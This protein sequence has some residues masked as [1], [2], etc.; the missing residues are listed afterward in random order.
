[1]KP[2]RLTVLTLIFIF[3]FISAASSQDSHKLLMNQHFPYP[4]RALDSIRAV[5]MPLLQLPESYR[6]RS[7]PPWVDNT[8]NQ[9]WPGV[10]DQ[11]L[12]SSCQQY[13]GVAYVFGYEI[14]RLRN[15]PG[16]YWEN[17]YPTHYTWNFM[18][19]GEE[20]AGVNFFESFEVIRQQGHMTSN[21]YGIDTATKALGW[22]SGYDKYYRGMFNHLKQ[23]SAIMT[24]STNGVNTL[25]N[26]LFDHLNG[27]ATG[28]IVCFTTD[29]SAIFGIPVIPAGFPEAGK[30]VVLAW[31]NSPNHGMTV[32][33]YNDSVKYDVNG[34]GKCTND[35]DITGDGIVDARDWEIGGFKIANSY[36]GGSW[37]D[38]G[39]TYALYRSFALNYEQG[40]VWNNR[41]YVVEADTA[42]RPL[43][44]LKVKLNYNYRDR[45]RILA[46]VGS[47]TM[48]QMPE[49]VIDF[50]IFN[51][52]G[53]EHVMQGWDAKPE[54]TSIEFGLDVTQLLNLVPS[55]Q[56]ARYFL[57]VEERDSVHTGTGS[58]QKASFIS[59]QNG[60]HEFPVNNENVSIE[61]N[62]VTFVSAVASIEK[63]D[64]QI[65]TNTLPQVI[66]SQP[67]QTQLMA[68]GG[69]PPYDWSFVEN[70]TKQPA[71]ALL[72]LITGNSLVTSSVIKPF[73][74]VA[75]PFS[76]PFFG[77]TF[78]SIYVNFKGYIT[79][80]P[81][82]LPGLFT[83]NENSMLRMIGSIAP[84]FSQQFTYQAAKN[85]GIFLQADTSRVIIRWKAT[86][87]EHLTNS[88]DDFALILYPDGRFEF[89]YG[90]MDNQGFMLTCYTGISKGD[91]LN[92]DVQTLWNANDLSGKSFRFIP[93]V[94]PAGLTLSKQGVLTCTQ[95][96]STQL[97][98]LDIR[99]ADAGKISAS[100][101]LMFSSGLEIGCQIAGDND[102][103]LEFGKTEKM[104]LLITNTGLQP[105][106]NLILTLRSAD[107]LL[108]IQDSVYTI[109]LLQPAQ[110]LTVP[111]A[112]AFG[113]KQPLPNGFP[114]LLSLQSQSGQ[115][116]WHKAAEFTVAAPTMFFQTPQLYDGCNN[117]LD[118]GEV[119]DLVVSVENAGILPSQT[120]ELKLVSHDT[121]VTIL[122]SS[123]IAIDQVDPL[124]V[125][126]FRYQVQ[127]SRHTIPGKEIA[128]E[129]LLTDSTGVIQSL[130]FPLM[131]GKKQ[132]ALASLSA[133]KSSM[134][135]M[136]A[137][138]DSLHVG[139]D[140]IS[141]LPFDYEHYASV[142]LI[143]GTSSSGWHTLTVTEASA[144]VNYLQKNGN[145]Y[146]EG[147]LTW[148]Y[149]N[150]TPLHPYF[151]YTTLKIPDFTYQNISGVPNTFTDSMSFSYSAPLNHSIFSFEPV[152]PA[153]STL[154]N[155]DNPPENFEI[156]YHGNDYKTIGTFLGFSALGGS[157]SSSTQVNLMRHYLEFF[158]FNIS[159]PFPF[160]HAAATK[161]CQGKTLDFTDDSYDHITSWSWEFPGGT[162]ASSTLQNPSIRY[163]SIGK[164]DV[165]LTV[166]D[167]SKTQSIL[168]S[169]YITVDR[170]AGNEDL[171]TQPWF[172]IFPN[173]ASDKVNIDVNGEFN[174]T[175]RVI[176]FDFTGRKV[177][178]Q[179][180]DPIAK[181][182][183]I[184]IDISGFKKGL[185]FLR[186]QSG[187]NTVTRKL[188]IY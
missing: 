141:E 144:L 130:D 108:N 179:Q 23:V 117:I 125:Q 58:I 43:L 171:L 158:G 77:R 74:P 86:V 147:Y 84:A 20:Y 49:H 72:P 76:F 173:P 166:S 185:Y 12:F 38:S 184:T 81:L 162:P 75:L 132:V 131:V 8:K 176:L 65:T 2:Y 140:T 42:Y 56:P 182:R 103:H 66:P 168:K 93:P 4:M 37:A 59:Y 115:R 100:K 70:Y 99:V 139:F 13:A 31:M 60:V 16:W 32:V 111:V 175:F 161:V 123:S 154:V 165:R 109:A 152:S 78:D 126:E 19:Q 118:P 129:L 96:D 27:S 116:F 80:E 183:T 127:A 40:G 136:A 142:F 122:S 61:D 11:F 113:L 9:Y 172:S 47:D 85:D 26:Y 151:K 73:T 46:G 150:S 121:L 7:L 156:V 15:R 187:K 48:S 50:P 89:R 6:N 14:N 69:R 57:A 25:K 145:L 146:M 34:D 5:R 1:M 68:E 91:E 102:N 41:V 44:A 133:S 160:F 22:I 169:S 35:I 101:I 104:K 54:A 120:M 181:G 186:V 170:C 177:L 105:I 33:G 155:A 36:G 29:G 174:G 143:L 10:L 128:M 17:G 55:G 90:T 178:E 97:Y 62:K 124:S 167:G 180:S 52:Q 88:T 64:V 3:T 107:S 164:F 63:P 92:Y 95:A 148:Y 67:Y 51:F 138:L 163:D 112:F 45:I 24:N 39:F 149:S 71:N 188:I 79:F 82:Y 94:I 106:Q 83:T 30:H 110:T 87:K 114:V 28:G 119:A 135:A 137:A 159:G 153:Y 134:V 18:N 21:D 98:D 157:T 53:G